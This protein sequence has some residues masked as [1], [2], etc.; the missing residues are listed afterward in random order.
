MEVYSDDGLPQ[1]KRMNEDLQ[2]QFHYLTAR[3]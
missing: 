1:T 2:S 3:A